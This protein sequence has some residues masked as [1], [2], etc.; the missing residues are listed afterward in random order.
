M[1]RYKDYNYHQAKMI[2]IAFKDQILPGTFEYT[3]S[4]LI[5]HELDLSLFDQR[6]AN[7]ET[8]RPAYDPALLLKIVLY[9][10]SRGIVSSRQIE[11][12]CRENVIFMAL[13]ADTQPHFTTIAEFISR[14][15]AEIVALFRNVL[16][17]C[18]AQG[19]IGKEMFAIDGCK[20]ASNAS[21]E[22]S[23]TKAE[24][25][26]K[27]R[28]LERAIRR[29]LQTHRERDAQ[30]VNA[31]LQQRE[32]Q[33]IATLKHQVNKL[34]AWLDDL[35][36]KPG[37]TGKPRKSNVTDNDSAKI[38]TSHGVIQGYDGVAAVD[39]KHQ[40][41][42]HGEAYGEAQE[43]E[44]LQPMLERTQE[45]FA[46]LND[47]N[48]YRRTKI[49]ADSGF[50]TE[51]NVQYL[52]THA[53]DGYVADNR[54][55][56]RDARFADVDKYKARHRGRAA[57]V[58]RPGGAVPQPGLSLRPGRAD[59]RV[60]G[61]QGAVSQRTQRRH[62]RLCGGEVQGAQIGLPALSAAPPLPE[63][64]RA[65]R[66][67]P[68][69]VFQRR[70]PQTRDLHPSDE[71]QDRLGAGQGRLQPAHCHG[72]A[73]VRALAQHRPG[74]IHAQ[75]QKEGRCS[76]ET[77]LHRAQSAEDPPIRGGI[78]LTM[79][80]R[81]GII[82]PQPINNTETA[83]LR[84]KRRDDPCICSHK[85]DAVSAPPFSTGSLAIER[86]TKRHARQHDGCQLYRGNIR[87]SALIGSRVLPESLCVRKGWPNHEAK[88]QHDYSRCSRLGCSN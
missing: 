17:I 35:D 6:Y 55:R 46:A 30:E 72:R 52:A 59:V 15:E 44:L 82:Q 80:P 16:L 24:L 33:Y 1:A 20:L 66:S 45:H 79:G 40:I 43:H 53:I 13:S 10:Y 37:K 69:G 12:C 23:G 78:W 83:S 29:M 18:D 50:H 14:M 60:P 57:P 56:S 85:R 7:D 75:R 76:V 27:K 86:Q 39:D 4:Y 2:P 25:T 22:W 3:L 11:R 67:A 70:D 8:G 58:A 51:R 28:K 74:P 61:R 36:D 47:A 62:Q 77:V 65:H 54:M 5:D 32:A 88:N 81:G 26:E 49:T 34:K 21:K 71:A 9:A 64:P 38:K 84:S 63:V 31:E 68:G 73:G 48:V 87:R 42:V 19:L 41:I